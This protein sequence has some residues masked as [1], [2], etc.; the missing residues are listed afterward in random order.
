MEEFKYCFGLL[1]NMASWEWGSF[2]YVAN[3]KPF[4]IL[5]SRNH[6]GNPL[7]MKLAN[8]INKTLCCYGM[9]SEFEND[10]GL[11]INMAARCCASFILKASEHF[12]EQ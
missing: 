7:M 8:N 12:C 11:F 3:V 9:W 10:F 1:K 6:I 2:P 4:H 5:N